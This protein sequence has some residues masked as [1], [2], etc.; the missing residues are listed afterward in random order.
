[1]ALPRKSGRSFYLSEPVFM[2][3]HQD[4]SSLCIRSHGSKFH[5]LAKWLYVFLNRKSKTP[6]GAVGKDISPQYIDQES[7]TEQDSR[8]LNN[9]FKAST[10]IM[11][12]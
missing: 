12:K 1:M 5:S 9:L 7:V 11:N 2:D 10:T 3:I 4:R 8:F 6:G